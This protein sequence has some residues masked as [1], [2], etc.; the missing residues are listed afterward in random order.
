MR[1]VDYFLEDTCG[2]EV[3][4]A[5]NARTESWDQPCVVEAFGRLKTWVDNGWLVPDFLNVAPNDAR[6]PMYLGDAAMVYEGPWFEGVLI[7]DQQ[8]LANFDFFLPPTASGRYHGFPEQ[9]MI[10]AGAKN[11]EGAVTFIDWITNAENQKP[12]PLAFAGSATIGVTPT[13]PR[14]RTAASGPRS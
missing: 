6:M 1:L 12:F 5:I 13:A 9:W 3:H 8:D 14:S 4:D 11:P 2:P 7:G 10:P